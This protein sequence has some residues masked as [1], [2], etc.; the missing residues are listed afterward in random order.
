MICGSWNKQLAKLNAGTVTILIPEKFE[1]YFSYDPAAPPRP[2]WGSVTG[3]D[4]S[5][6]YTLIPELEDYDY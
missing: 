3:Q 4:L 1:D 6:V 5:D 2:N